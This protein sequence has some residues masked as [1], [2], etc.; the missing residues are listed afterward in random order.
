MDTVPFGN[1]SDYKILLNDWPYGIDDRIKHLVV[2]VKF[3]FD[4]DP[5]TGDLT[6]KSRRQ[7]EDFVQATFRKGDEN[8]REN[9]VWFKN[10]AQLKSVHAIEHFHVMIF[11]PDP[12]FLKEVTGEDAGTMEKV[13]ATEP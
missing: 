7:I 8:G 5:Q 9:V 3:G 4:E 12:A 6:P 1:S 11:D 13:L 10:W 2:W